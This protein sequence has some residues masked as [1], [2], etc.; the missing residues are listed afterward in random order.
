MAV[1]GGVINPRRQPRYGIGTS[2]AF[3]SDG[4][5]AEDKVVRRGEG[6]STPPGPVNPSALR[7][8][9]GEIEVRP[10]RKASGQRQQHVRKT[11]RH[12]VKRGEPTF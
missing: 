9:R 6:A 7:V 4:R 12:R 2:T 8:Y 5:S 10:V 1:G 11:T 3:Q